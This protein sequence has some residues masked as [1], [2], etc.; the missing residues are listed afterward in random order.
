MLD[1]YNNYILL[2]YKA[3]KCGIKCYIENTTSI[4]LST[5]TFS[6]YKY[7]SF[8]KQFLI[9]YKSVYFYTFSYIYYMLYSI[10]YQ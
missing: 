2:L 5:Y 3:Y 9:N 10:L 6:C 7:L 1:N 4:L 8:G